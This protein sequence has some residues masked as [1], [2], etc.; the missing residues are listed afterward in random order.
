[1]PF[2]ATAL[3]FS[4]LTN[5]QPRQ[6]P[7]SASVVTIT[8]AKQWTDFAMD[9]PPAVDFSTHSVLVVFAGERPTGG[10]KV[11][12]TGVSKNADACEVKYTVAGP[13]KGTMVTQAFTHPYAV[14]LVKGKCEKAVAPQG[15]SGRPKM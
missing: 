9:A 15:T 3:T 12:V 10:W 4:L 1:M 7:D 8:S 5:V 11:N 13:P 14:V 6:F 2:L